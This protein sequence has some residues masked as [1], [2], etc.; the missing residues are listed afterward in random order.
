MTIR[1]Q[2][3]RRSSHPLP[4]VSLPAGLLPSVLSILLLSI[5][6]ASID[7]E[8]VLRDP[9]SSGGTAPLDRETVA[10]GLR[11]ALRVGSGRAV[12]RTSRV[13]GFLANELIRITI[14][15]ELRSMTDALRR[16]GLSRQVDQLEVQLNRAAE[17]AA[18]EAREVFWSEIREI[19]FPD[20]WAILRGG[21]TAAT[22]FLERRTRPTIES[23][24]RPIVAEKIDEVGLGRTYG[25]LARRY[26]ALP[27][28]TRPAL[29]LDD[30]V[31]T[32]AVDGLFEV[33]AEEERK[34]RED[35]LARTTELLR[36]VFGRS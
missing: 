8:G 9:G 24:F 4:A 34:I 7:L 5:G 11:D 32:E 33:L 13:D 25:D 2:A 16:L 22:D 30:Y 20:A 21:Q 35:P 12:D 14:P 1:R 28:V 3:P 17:A 29:D 23:R 36:R 15:E 31:T 18:S 6:C 27:F 26:N 10:S 19:T